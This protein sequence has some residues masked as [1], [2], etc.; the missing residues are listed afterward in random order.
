M[1]MGMGMAM[2]RLS[3]RDLLALWE[4]AG[5]TCAPER[6]L[7]LL[8]YGYPELTRG[9]LVALSLGQ[10]DELLLRLRGRAFGDRMQSAA[11]CPG[12]GSKLEF[13]LTVEELCSAARAPAANPD[14]D[15]ELT[16]H[17][18]ALRFRLPTSKDLLAI[19]GLVRE[20]P[21][22]AMAQLIRGCVLS[23]T[24]SDGALPGQA[25]PAE[26]PRDLVDA[27]A[28]RITESDPLAEILLDLTCPDCGHVW[29]AQLD[30]ATFL[31]TELDVQ[32][33]RL[34]AELCALAQAFGWTEETIL[35]L[36]PRRRRAYLQMVGA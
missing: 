9:E 19:E 20:Q 30:I 34:L 32:A 15:Q 13:E 36:S 6:V 7:G 18:Y 26:L 35:A 1:G 11:A 4:R 12:C 31:L 2:G 28:R 14:A 33:R 23:I 5:E 22:L 16:W 10:R 27:L 29:Q 17:Q 24:A 8:A 3:D 25:L 21:Q